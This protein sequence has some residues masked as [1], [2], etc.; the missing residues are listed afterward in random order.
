MWAWLRSV[1]ARL[2]HMSHGASWPWPHPAR[3]SSNPMHCLGNLLLHPAPKGFPVVAEPGRAASSTSCT[4]LIRLQAAATAGGGIRGCGITADTCRRFPHQLVF[5]KAPRRL[6]SCQ[7][8]RRAICL[9]LPALSPPGDKY[10]ESREPAGARQSPHRQRGRPPVLC[11]LGAS[12]CSLP[13]HT[14]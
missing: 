13:A 9:A 3:A 7:P 10:L 5:L 12:T 2:W 6:Q 4:A 11:M 1:G 8:R 14:C